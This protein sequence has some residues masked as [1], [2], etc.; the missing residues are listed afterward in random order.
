VIRYL[1]DTNVVSEVTKPKPHEHV[2][3][4]YNS[5]P[6]DQLAI[7]AITVRELA[8]GVANAEKQKSPRAAKYA[9]GLQSI[10]S[11][12]AGRIL[13]IDEAVALEWAKLLVKQLKHV[14]DKG[15]VATAKIHDLIM[16]S[17]NEDDVSGYG[18]EIL[19]PF[20]KITKKV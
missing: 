1:L 20:K 2:W 13:A 14:D 12:F 17:R 4:W 15:L 18:V 6:D 8:Y 3:A 7:S 5:I 19:N 16:V 10:R 11:G 9:A